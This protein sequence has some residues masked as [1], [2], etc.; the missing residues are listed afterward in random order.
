MNFQNMKARNHKILEIFVIVFAS[1]LKV[2]P[3]VGVNNYCFLK[4]LALKY[5]VKNNYF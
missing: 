2:I 1:K 5:F 3:G 4:Q